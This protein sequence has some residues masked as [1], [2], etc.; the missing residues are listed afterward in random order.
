MVNRSTAL[1]HVAR[2]VCTL[3]LLWLCAGSVTAGGG[4]SKAAPVGPKTDTVVLPHMVLRLGPDL[5]SAYSVVFSPDGATLATPVSDQRHS[6]VLWD[7]ARGTP[8]EILKPH[9][10]GAVGLQFLAD[11]RILLVVDHLVGD[12][13][14]EDGQRHAAV[15]RWDTVTGKQTGYFPVPG[16]KT[17]KLISPDGKWLVASGPKY[18]DAT[19]KIWDIATAK[20]LAG[21]DGGADLFSVRGAVFS[22]DGKVLAVGG[23]KDKA[24]QVLLIDCTTFKEL[25]RIDSRGNP[26][27]TISLSAKGDL[28]AGYFGRHYDGFTKTSHGGVEIWDLSTGKQLPFKWHFAHPLAQLSPDGTIIAAAADEGVGLW[29]VPD[30]K[31]LAW[32]KG[33]KRPM[34]HV[35]FSADAG[36]LAGTDRSSDEVYIWRLPKRQPKGAPPTDGK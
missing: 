29:T 18:P 6:I 16:A 9:S 11:Q 13:L 35:A 26:P 22:A 1:A 31:P 20:E 25:R 19:L 15:R 8:R 10:G 28:L 2:Q 3:S 32:L 14:P 34:R 7:V 5:R 27:E 33:A 21:F 23:G 30:G 12:D 24:G 36:L 17:G 4:A